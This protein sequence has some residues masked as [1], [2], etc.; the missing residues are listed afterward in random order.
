MTTPRDPRTLLPLTPLA[1]QVLLALAHGPRHGYGILRDVTDRSDG[2]FRLKTGT[3]YVLLPRLSA[4]GLVEVA[5]AS[6]LEDPGPTPGSPRRYYRLT[7]FG[8]SVLT[9]ES[10]RMAAAASD[11]ARALRRR[12]A[13]A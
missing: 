4:E 13:K 6:S 9:A 3:L 2:L 5:P 11:A 12:D 8:R 10:R 1:F 7:S